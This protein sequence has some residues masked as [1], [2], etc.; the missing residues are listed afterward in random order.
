MDGTEPCDDEVLDGH[1]EAH[2]AG[3]A[4]RGG[5]AGQGR[6][7]LAGRVGGPLAG[8]GAEVDGRLGGAHPQV[9]RERGQVGGQRRLGRAHAQDDED[10][11]GLVPGLAEDDQG[12]RREAVGLGQEASG[13]EVV[14]GMTPEEQQ[15]ATSEAASGAA[16]DWV[17]QA[18]AMTRAWMTALPTAA[19]GGSLVG[20]WMQQWQALARNS[21]R[22]WP[23]ESEEGSREAA[24]RLLTG[25]HAFLSVAEM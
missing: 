12:R 1:A 5:G 11:G 2:V 17:E 18:Q 3:M 20:D 10:A 24:T 23:T 22:G 25:E 7:Q 6:G 4:R 9:R 21:L 13:T 19:A 14:G 8:D 15:R 16:A